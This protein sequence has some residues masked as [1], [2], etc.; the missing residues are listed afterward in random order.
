MDD[1]QMIL[2]Q[3]QLDQQVLMIDR[4]LD[5]R[6]TSGLDFYDYLGEEKARFY[7]MLQIYWLLGGKEYLQYKPK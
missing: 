7:G 4:I 1:K 6:E 3:Q 2:V 5:K